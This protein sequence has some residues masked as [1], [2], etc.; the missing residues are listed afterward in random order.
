MAEGSMAPC[1]PTS[2]EAQ[3]GLQGC[4]QST[5]GLAVCVGGRAHAGPPQGL[6]RLLWPSV[7]AGAARLLRWCGKVGMSSGSQAAGEE[8]LRAR[9]QGRQL[10]SRPGHG[11]C[12]RASPTQ[13]CLHPACP[14]SPSTTKRATGQ[15]SSQRTEPRGSG[16]LRRGF[17]LK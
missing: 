15:T 12:P 17:S 3:P 11:A 1:I 13:R 2:Q 8:Q 4:S 9:L 7:V 16:D 14:G 6:H 5:A 10:P